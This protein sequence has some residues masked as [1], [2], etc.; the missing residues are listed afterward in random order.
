MS[1]EDTSIVNVN[2]VSETSSASLVSPSSDSTALFVA[3]DK[4]LKTGSSADDGDSS[5]SVVTTVWND[6]ISD[7]SEI[8]TAESSESLTKSD[9][10]S[11]EVL[12]TITASVNNGENA[13]DSNSCTAAASQDSSTPA[14]RNSESSTPAPARPCRLSARRGGIFS[15]ARRLN[16]SS[17]TTPSSTER[18]M[19]VTPARSIPATRRRG[20]SPGETASVASA[21]SKTIPHILSPPPYMNGGTGGEKKEKSSRQRGGGGEKSHA[22]LFRKVCEID[23]FFFLNFFFFR[24]DIEVRATAT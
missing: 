16:N 15:T 9:V 10:K 23:C 22:E 14:T 1:S 17:L 12:E 21:T 20:L 13:T 4:S 2:S 8:A 19:G 11:N 24:T 3:I 7:M 18:S 5:Q 6:K